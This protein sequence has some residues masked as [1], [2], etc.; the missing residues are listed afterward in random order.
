MHLGTSPLCLSPGSKLNIKKSSLSIFA[1][2]FRRIDENGDKKIDYTDFEIALSEYGIE[3]D[4][5]TKKECF[6]EMDL[7]GTGYVN[8]DEFLQALRVSI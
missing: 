4:A 8:F 7:D 1:R 6:N 2:I 3:A 5:S